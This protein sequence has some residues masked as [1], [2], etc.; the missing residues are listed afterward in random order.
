MSDNKISGF[1]RDLLVA[2]HEAGHA[3]ICHV[4][5]YDFKSITIEHNETLGSDGAFCRSPLTEAKEYK[6]LSK[7]GQN[8]WL[9]DKIKITLSGGLATLQLTNNP[10]TVGMEPDFDIARSLAKMIVK[11]ENKVSELISALSALTRD[12]LRNKRNWSAI[13]A[14][15]NELIKRR[16]INYDDAVK[17]IKKSFYDFD[18]IASY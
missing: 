3:V 10:E 17:I 15:A 6:H 8:R 9:C 18:S 16:T 4:L 14:L 12:L 5:G 13:N 1:D 7:E 2:T 11:D